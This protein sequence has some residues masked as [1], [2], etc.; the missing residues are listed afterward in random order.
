MVYMQKELKG[1]LLIILI[2]LTTKS[3][4]NLENSSLSEKPVINNIRLQYTVHEA[5]K[6]TN[7]GNL[8]RIMSRQSN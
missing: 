8:N 7:D 2:V 1:F 5:I 4:L 3:Y 6:I